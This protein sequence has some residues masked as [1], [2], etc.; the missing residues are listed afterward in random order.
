MNSNNYSFD[1]ITGYDSIKKKLKMICDILKN[2]EYYNNLD[3]RSPHGL[4]LY[5]EPGVGKT[6]M[7]N[8]LISETGRKSFV[9]RKDTSNGEF[10]KN[11]RQVFDDAIDAAPSIVFLDD[12][13]KFANEDKDHKNDRGCLSAICQTFEGLFKYPFFAFSIPAFFHN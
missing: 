13:D 1:D 7:S 4:L 5:G 12:M 3:V 10:L 9:C 8:V 2:E 6:L 11:I